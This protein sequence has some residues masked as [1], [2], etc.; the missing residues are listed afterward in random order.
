[1]AKFW[2]KPTGLV[3]GSLCSGGNSFCF[4]S[5][6][7]QDLGQPEDEVGP[8]IDSGKTASGAGHGRRDGRPKPED[9]RKQ[10]EGQAVSRNSS[11]E[12]QQSQEQASNRPEGGADVPEIK[13]VYQA[14]FAGSGWS[15]EYGD[16][17]EC[18]ESRGLI[19]RLLKQVSGDSRKD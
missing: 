9:G 1:M 12:S 10:T 8:G 19:R 4:L 3:S 18:A 6:R 11:Q 7:I 5:L 14:F 13:A 16:N 15:E 17:F 2:K